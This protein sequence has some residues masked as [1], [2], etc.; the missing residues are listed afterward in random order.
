MGMQTLR[1]VG[2]WETDRLALTIAQALYWMNHQDLFRA[3][4][5]LVRPGGGVA[6]VTNGTPLWLQETDW[7]RALREFLQH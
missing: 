5:P 1:C 3:V 4:V 6:V 2:C 7:S